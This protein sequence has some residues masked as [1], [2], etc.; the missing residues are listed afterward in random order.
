MQHVNLKHSIATRL[1]RVIFGLY[2]VVTI[3][4]TGTQM[5]AEYQLTSETVLDEIKQLEKTYGPGLGNALWTYNNDGLRSLLIGMYE[6]SSV[7]GVKI[8]Y[9]KSINAIGAIE[10]NEGEI[11]LYGP[12]NKIVEK[13][14]AHVFTGY[15]RHEF[16]IEYKKNSA[17]VITVGAGVIYT[18]TRIIFNRVKDGFVLIVL[19]AILK[20]LFLWFIFIYFIRKMLAKPLGELAATTDAVDFNNLIPN[21]VDL[22]GEKD[23]EL[24]VLQDSFNNMLYKLELSKQQIDGYSNNLEEII[25]ERTEKLES[26]IR[27]RKEAQDL[28]EKANE[29]KSMFIAN[30][31]HEIRTPMTSIY[32]MV[33]L[34]STSEL[35]SHQ[36]DKLEIIER[37]CER[38]LLIINEILDFSKLESGTD[39]IVNVKINLHNFISG[40]VESVQLLADE[41]KL[42]INIDIQ[43]VPD[44]IVIDTVKLAHVLTNLV[45]NAI[46]FTEQGVIRIT[47]QPDTF[48][49]TLLN[50]SVKDTGIGISK[51]DQKNLF[52]AFTQ[53]DGALSRKYSG[54]GLGLAISNKYI[55]LMGGKIWVESHLGEGSTFYF[56]LPLEQ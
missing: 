22:G 24:H 48:N 18:S 25:K 34:L 20:T 49:Y 5:Y 8:E 40:V 43:N 9:E 6:I 10:D 38:L 55:D 14:T 42:N 33:R 37:N 51:D 53:V 1:L 27:V 4:L 26:E 32:G 16:P 29:Y 2:L 46:K 3:I 54:T 41:K 7:A 44:E 19:G 11:V 35:N 47:V 31:S 23:D 17:D 15:I 36:H 45:G 21:K 50:F 52:E 12:D 13:E 28:S 30:I 56:T 39:K